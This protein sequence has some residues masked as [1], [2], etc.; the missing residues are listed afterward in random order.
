M[1]LYIQDVVSDFF[2][3]V[4]GDCQRNKKW[5]ARL[6]FTAGCRFLNTFIKNEIGKRFL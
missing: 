6:G 5:F 2:Q 1:R 4:S 3:I